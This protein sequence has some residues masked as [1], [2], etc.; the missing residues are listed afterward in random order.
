MIDGTSDDIF[1]PTIGE[2]APTIVGLAGLQAQCVPRP[3]TPPPARPDQLRPT[4]YTLEAC[5]QGA[6]P[7]AGLA[8]EPAAYG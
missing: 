5:S 8:A 4:R 2:A 1:Y 6:M 3:I 7:R